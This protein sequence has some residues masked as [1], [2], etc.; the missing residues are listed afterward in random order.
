MCYGLDEEGHPRRVNQIILQAEMATW[1]G[2]P[3]TPD[4]VRALLGKSRI[5]ALC[6]LAGRELLTDAVLS[7]LHAVEAAL[8]QRIQESGGSSVNV[9]GKPLAWSD[10]FQRAISLGLVG[11]EPD[12]LN[13]DLIDYGRNL[14]NSLSHPTS[15]I[16]MP[17]AAALPLIETSHRLVARLFPDSSQAD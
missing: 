17:Y 13:R 14:R 5:A 6:S 16:Y 10:L 3:A 15:V 2:T 9:R 12:E 11:R 7:S 1:P 4:N 8:R